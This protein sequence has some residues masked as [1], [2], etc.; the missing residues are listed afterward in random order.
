MMTDT[1]K[2]TTVPGLRPMETAPRDGKEFLGLTKDDIYV[3]VTSYHEPEFDAPDNLWD[4]DHLTHYVPNNYFQGWLPLPT[5]ETYTRDEVSQLAERIAQ[6]E[7][8]I[9]AILGGINMFHN[10]YTHVHWLLIEELKRNN[11]AVAD[12]ENRKKH[13]EVV[14]A[15]RLSK[16]YINDDSEQKEAKEIL[17]QFDEQRATRVDIASRVSKEIEKT[18]DGKKPGDGEG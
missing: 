14:W 6:L 16:K 9:V 10:E 5:G 4:V 3:Q 15:E 2:K 8:D 17:E 11:R 18:K 12:V 1:N 7:N 13:Y